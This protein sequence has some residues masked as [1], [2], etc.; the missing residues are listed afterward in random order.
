MVNAVLCVVL[1]V[2]APFQPGSRETGWRGAKRD[3]IVSVF[4]PPASWPEKP[5]QVWKSAAGTGHSS[6]VVAGP[7]QGTEEL[8]I[9]SSLL[10]AEVIVGCGRAIVPHESPP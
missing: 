1:M 8:R 4:T 7:R 5:K 3:A 2:T 10:L 6:P 9:E